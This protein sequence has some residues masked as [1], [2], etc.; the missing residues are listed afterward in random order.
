MN[1][2]T[3]N[4]GIMIITLRIDRVCNYILVKKKKDKLDNN[5]N[6][7]KMQ[8]TAIIRKTLRAMTASRLK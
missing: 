6:L 3:V 7:R 1:Y 5:V 2:D 4:S 8:V